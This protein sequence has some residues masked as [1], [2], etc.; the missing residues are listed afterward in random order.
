MQ[1]P[2]TA[3]LYPL[4]LSLIVTMLFNK[5]NQMHQREK[6]NVRTKKED[7]NDGWSWAW[8]QSLHVKLVIFR[9]FIYVYFIF[10]TVHLLMY[11]IRFFTVSTR[12]F[13][14]RVFH[15][16]IPLLH[17]AQG[18]SNLKHVLFLAHNYIFLISTIYKK[19]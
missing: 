11:S 10:Y 19:I 13:S 6:K 1:W 16:P 14:R 7:E 15:F 2:P 5:L 4:P 17:V 8:P 18:P 3:R 12:I 9:I